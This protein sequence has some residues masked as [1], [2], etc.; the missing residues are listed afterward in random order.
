MNLLV[1]RPA[2]LGSVAV[3]L[4][5]VAGCTV[6]PDPRPVDPVVSSPREA[7]AAPGASV[8]PHIRRMV[9]SVRES[10]L[11]ASV[12]RLAGFGTRHTLSEDVSDTR[13]VGAA[14][15]WV[16]S[17][18]EQISEACGGCITVETPSDVVTA[19]RIPV[20]TRVVHVLGVQRGAR[21]PERVIIISAHLDS[22]ASD[23]MDA[24][25][26][27]PGANDDASGVAAVIEAARVLARHRFDATIVYAALTG[28][29]QGLVG[30]RILAAHALS[31]GWRVGAVLNN[32][33]IGNTEGLT[34]YR[35]GAHVRVFAEGV[36]ASETDDMARARRSTGGEVDSPARNLARF[37]DRLS[38]AYT[39]DLKVRMIYRTDRFGRGGDQIPMLESGFAA[40]RIT[41]AVENYRRQHQNVRTENGV[42]YGDVPAGVDFPY[43]ARVT[44]LN[45]AALAMLASA[46]PPPEMVALEGAVSPDTTLK[47][48]P[49]EGATGYRV[50]RRPTTEP[51]W[52]LAADAPADAT[53][54]TLSG[55]VIDDWFFGVSSLGP[56]GRE[57]PVQFPGAIGAFAPPAASSTTP[58]R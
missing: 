24:N 50:W 36:R 17:E 29:E 1:R 22:R 27:A 47:W 14:R 13:G 55:V 40:V 46:P 44:R 3:V 34:G 21:T 10:R 18:F 8:D 58:A 53:S 20:P 35:D 54:L 30:G 4:T 45:V 31:Q 28:E 33:I 7:A 52:T 5:L 19:P 39:P 38:A 42:A 56:D 12:Q 26:D 16:A 41:E 48:T 49:V 6:S 15:R 37:L 11:E 2:G 57:S 32:D 51:Q 23:V 25:I 9:E 43:L